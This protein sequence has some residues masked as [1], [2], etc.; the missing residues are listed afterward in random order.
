LAKDFT[1][2]QSPSILFSWQ[3]H[4]ARRR[5]LAALLTVLV[6]A[7]A[8]FL[9]GSLMEQLGWGIFAAVALVV[10]ANRFFFLTH[11]E[12]DQVGITARFPLKT[13]RYRWEELRRFIYDGGGGY[14]SPRAKA[15]FLDEYRGIS[16]LFGPVTLSLSPDGKGN[17]NLVAAD[18][19]IREIRS[20]MP[21][22]AIVRE[23]T[24][25]ARRKE[26]T[27]CSG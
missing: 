4:P 8:A 14:L 26:R 12:L 11:Y 15:S 21:A 20:R 9:A 24:T 3:V 23:L 18:T 19:I 7:A 17:K 1:L 10:G 13:V 22:E 16:L 27:P 2:D 6:I 5:P 25:T